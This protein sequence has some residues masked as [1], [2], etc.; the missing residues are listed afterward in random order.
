MVLLFCKKSLK[1]FIAV[2]FALNLPD[3]SV[4]IVFHYIKFPALSFIH[5]RYVDSQNS[6]QHEK[7]VNGGIT[8]QDWR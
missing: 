5:Q 1:I 8:I 2:Q 4:D 3:V 7:S 6:T